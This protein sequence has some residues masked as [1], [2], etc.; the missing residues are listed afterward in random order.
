VFTVPK[1]LRRLFQRDRRLLGI[2]SRSAFRALRE[3]IC[4][5]LGRTDVVPGFV[6]S[7]QTFGSFLNWQPHV[8]SLVSEGGFTVDG[9]FV[10]L[11]NLDTDAVEARFREYVIQG[12]QGAD[13]LSSEFAENLRSWEHSG[14]D[15]FAGRQM[16]VGET[17][18]SRRWGGT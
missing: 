4:D 10:T 8:H 18:R 3:V 1:A 5:E 7:L 11:W 17:A 9:D 13:R 15:V 12:L 14:F 16:T 2:L 6:A